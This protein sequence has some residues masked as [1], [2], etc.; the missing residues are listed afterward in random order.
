MC[1][2]HLCR[3][4]SSMLLALV[5]P[6]VAHQRL[7]RG[8]PP[9]PLSSIA[10]AHGKGSNT[11]IEANRNREAFLQPF[12]TKMPHLQSNTLYTPPNSEIKSG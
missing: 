9:A 1:V 12:I 3:Q 8:S 6:S 5:L 2:Y 4:L 7:S 11:S 10:K